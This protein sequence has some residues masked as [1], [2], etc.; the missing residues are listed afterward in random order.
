MEPSRMFFDMRLY[1]QKILIDELGGLFVVVR[2]G[3]QPSTGSSGR[4]RTEIQQEGTGLFFRYEQTLIYILAPLN[5]HIPSFGWSRLDIDG[6]SSG[7]V[8]ERTSGSQRHS[9]A[10]LNQ[11]WKPRNV[12]FLGV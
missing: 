6:Q 4:R 12:G 5:C 7:G 1:R 11:W 9:T 2:L 3:I 10:V 8:T